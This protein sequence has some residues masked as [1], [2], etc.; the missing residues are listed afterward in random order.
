[1]RKDKHKKTSSPLAG[2]PKG[3]A[4]SVDSAKRE[5]VVMD[6]SDLKEMEEEFARKQKAKVARQRRKSARDDR[7]VRLG[8]FEDPDAGLYGQQSSP[9]ERREYRR[10]RRSYD[11]ETEKEMR[12]EDRAVQRAERKRRRSSGRSGGGGSVPPKKGK[13]KGGCLKKIITV[14]IILALIGGGAFLFM[15]NK[16]SKMTRI[17]T[18][19]KDFDISDMANERLK[20]YRNIAVLGIDARKGQGYEGSRSDAIVVVSIDKKTNEIKLIS[21]MR[22]SYLYMQGTDGSMMLDK[23][24]HAHAFGGPV[25]TCATLNRSLDLNIKEFVVLNW[26]AVADAVDTMGGLELDVKQN[27]IS[28]LNRWGPETAT[29]TDRSWNGITSPG[30][31]QMDGAQVATYCRIRKTSGGD[32]GRNERYK[33]VMSAMFKKAKTSP[34]KVN[35][36]MDKVFPQIVTNMSSA[37]VMKL[38]PVVIDMDMKKSV[39]WPF[40]YYGGIIGGKWLAVP[41]TLETNNAELYK[42]AFKIDDY[43]MSPAASEIYNMIIN[44]TGIQ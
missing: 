12:K 27:E 43:E 42:K 8:G 32:T 29:N 30:K 28:D 5:T 37:Q 38:I 26:N 35:K 25:N 10:A 21:V 36:A 23:V 19:D 11:P 6:F 33:K 7:A 31:Q 15:N 13:Q 22:D 14:L 24:T 41:R 9:E 40:D 34:N 3:R 2:K 20:N 16:L 44:S 18:T 39:G 1:M 17:K 4:A